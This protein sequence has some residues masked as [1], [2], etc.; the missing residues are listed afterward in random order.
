MPAAT[1]SAAFLGKLAGALVAPQLSD[2]GRHP[3]PL[4]L[5]EPRISDWENRNGIA[6]RSAE[7]EMFRECLKFGRLE[8]R[9]GILDDLAAY[10]GL[11]SSACREICI[12]WERRSIEEWKSGDRT[13][14]SGILD[15]YDVANSWTFDLLWYAYLQA[16]GHGLPA[17]AMVAHFANSRSSGRSHLDF[18]SGVGVTSQLFGRL[19]FEST[20]ADVSRPLLNF[21]VWRTRRRG[22]EKTAINLR[23]GRL[24]DDAYDVITA[25]DTLAHVPD[26]DEAAARLHRSLRLGGW[27]I[28]N[29]DVRPRKSDG[30]AWHLYESAA[31]LDHRLQRAGFICEET[32]GGVL[33]CYRKVNVRSAGHRARTLLRTVTLPARSLK[34]T[35]S[36]VR[37]PTPRRVKRLLGA[38][39]G[40]P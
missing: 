1:S 30:A 6:W 20:M 18:G 10:H 4:Y 31:V 7:M 36:R 39:T 19:G 8:I 35:M 13:T 5:P 15:F 11:S 38:K 29:F 22:E 32:L 14:E 27:L 16:F 24:P 9:E 37:W 25:V 21:A 3:D 34:E 40:L 17:S 12:D 33:R 23:E 28:A 2:Q 26:F